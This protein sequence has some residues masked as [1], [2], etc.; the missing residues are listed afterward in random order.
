MYVYLSRE[1]ALALQRQFDLVPLRGEVLWEAVVAGGGG[2]VG[3]GRGAEA[4][5]CLKKKM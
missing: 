5:V 4:G 2:G 3:I 1:P